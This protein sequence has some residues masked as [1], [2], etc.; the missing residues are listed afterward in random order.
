M[1]PV[2]FESRRAAEDLRLRTRSHWDRQY[3]TVVMLIIMMIMMIKIIII[4]IF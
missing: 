3:V 4:I 2:G 1:P